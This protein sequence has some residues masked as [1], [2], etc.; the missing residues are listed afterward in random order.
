M[1]SQRTDRTFIF[2]IFIAHYIFFD[3][4]SFRWALINSVMAL[5]FNC[6]IIDA[7]SAET[8]AGYSFLLVC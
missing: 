1:E 4:F 6:A 8:S 3:L 2:Y 7:L 5:V